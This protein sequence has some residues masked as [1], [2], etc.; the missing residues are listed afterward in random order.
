MCSWRETAGNPIRASS[1][2]MVLMDVN[3]P[4]SMSSCFKRICLYE[5]S[6]PI[7]IGVQVGV[8]FDLITAYMCVYQACKLLVSLTVRKKR[9]RKKRRMVLVGLAILVDGERCCF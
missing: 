1:A 5:K 3:I 8:F 4:K 9:W 7:S 2:A 6:T